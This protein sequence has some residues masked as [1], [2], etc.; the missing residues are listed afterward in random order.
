MAQRLDR[1]HDVRRLRRAQRP[2][3]I[4][5]ESRKSDGR[6]EPDRQRSPD[7]G[8]ASGGGQ[9]I[10]AARADHRDAGG[11]VR[12]TIQ[13]PTTFSAA[14]AKVSS[15]LAYSVGEPVVAVWKR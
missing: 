8:Q 7:V 5:A 13:S 3:R 6:G 10:G 1:P 15:I 2:L 9:G 11:E 12:A 14:G 4:E